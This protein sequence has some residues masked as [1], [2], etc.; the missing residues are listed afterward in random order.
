MALHVIQP[1]QSALD[2][3]RRL[4]CRDLLAQQ[5]DAVEPQNPVNFERNSVGLSR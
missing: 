2:V 1:C 4:Y 3:K 5:A